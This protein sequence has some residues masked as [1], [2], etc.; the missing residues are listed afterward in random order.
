[1][2]HIWR[3]LRDVLLSPV[4]C[5]LYLINRSRRTASTQQFSQLGNPV[6]SPAK[7]SSGLRSRTDNPLQEEVGRE[8]TPTGPR[9]DVLGSG[10]GKVNRWTWNLIILGYKRRSGCFRELL[11]SQL[12]LEIAFQNVMVNTSLNWCG[13]H[14]CLVSAVNQSFVNG[15]KLYN[16]VC[17]RTDIKYSVWSCVT[18]VDVVNDRGFLSRTAPLW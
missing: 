5:S 1:M 11:F 6:D 18:T 10:R 3:L 17:L 13:A 2:R 7:D 4:R 16:S 8:K 12:Y 14:A 9:K 15:K